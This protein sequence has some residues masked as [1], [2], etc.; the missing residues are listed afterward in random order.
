MVIEAPYIEADCLAF[1]GIHIE[2][3]R[4]E[5]VILLISEVTPVL[6][7]LMCQN[8]KFQQTVLLNESKPLRFIVSQSAILGQAAQLGELGE[9]NEF[10]NI[11]VEEAAGL[12]AVSDG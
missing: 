10:I 11:V 7:I 3:S 12:L 1:S 4:G 9:T 2:F 6:I 5:R 8:I